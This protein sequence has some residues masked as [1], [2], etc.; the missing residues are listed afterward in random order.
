MSNLAPGYRCR[1]AISIVTILSVAGA[2]VAISGAESVRAGRTAQITGADLQIAAL[3]ISRPE[4]AAGE[5]VVYSI[6]AR[7]DGPEAALGVRVI[8]RLP[9]GLTHVVD[10]SGGAYDVATGR[11]TIGSMEPG[12]SARLAITTTVQSPPLGPPPSGA[13]LGAFV[14]AG[15]GGLAGPVDLVFGP[16]GD[17]FVASALTD[18]VLR[19]DG[20]SGSAKGAFVSA[21]AGG[22]DVPDGLVFGPDGALYVAS[23]ETDAVLRFDGV[24]GAFESIFVAAGA[25]GLAGPA[26]LLFAPSGELIVASA[27]SSAVLRFSGSDGSFLG[28]LVAPGAGGLERPFGLALD[29]AGRIYV[30]D[31]PGDAVRRY[32]GSTGAPLGDFVTTGAGGLV[33]PDR[34]VF[35]PD[36]ALYVSNA[37]GGNV[38][39]FNGITG[40][41]TRVF[42]DL[43]AGGFGS[44]SGLVFGPEGDLLVS[45]FGGNAVVQFAG[46]V[47]NSARIESDSPYDPRPANNRRYVALAIRSGSMAA[48]A[49]L[50]LSMT[51]AGGVDDV[52]APGGV[53]SSPSRVTAGRGLAMNLVVTNAGPG[54]APGA[55]AR[56]TLPDGVVFVAGIV[57]GGSGDACRLEASGMFASIVRC[58]VGALVVGGLARVR[59]TTATAPGLAAGSTLELRATVGSDASEAFHEDN[60]ASRSVVVERRSDLEA[61]LEI[62]PEGPAG[63]AVVGDE[64]AITLQATNLGPSV[65]PAAGLSLTLPA[66]LV[67]TEVTGDGA[68]CDLPAAGV[69]ACRTTEI[70]PG[71]AARVVL[72][73]L[74]SDGLPGRMLESRGNV[75]A[76]DG[77]DLYGANDRAA[78]SLAIGEGP[79]PGSESESDVSVVEHVAEPT[80]PTPLGTLTFRVRVRNAGPGQARGVRVVHRL[81]PGTEYVPG[82]VGP[83]V[84]EP[85]VMAGRWVIGSM[86]AGESAEIEL[87]ARVTGIVRPEWPAATGMPR[88]VLGGGD[89]LGAPGKLV[90]G[91]DGDI[92]VA[93]GRGQVQRFDG[94]TGSR[95]PDFVPAGRELL[96][97]SAVAWGPDGDLYVADATS[98]G[99]RRFD[100]VL[101]SEKPMFVTPGAGGLASPSD[102]AWGSDGRLY[103]ADQLGSRILRFHGRTGEFHDVVVPEGR[104][105]L[106][107]PSAIA[108]GP[109]G[110]LWVSSFGSGE[111]LRFSAGSGDLIGRMAVRSAGLER[112]ST[113]LF[114]LFG[115]LLASGEAAGQVWRFGLDG[116]PMGRFVDD[117]SV[118]AGVSGLAFGLDGHLL[119][120]DTRRGRVGRND[121][122]AMAWARASRSE[123]V[124]INMTNDR[125][126]AGIV[127]P[128][129]SPPEPTAS[130]T[131]S[132]TRTATPGPGTDTPPASTPE[133]ILLPI[134]A[135]R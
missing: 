58:D 73:A 113:I 21:G 102:L 105:G 7:N 8:D 118:G 98:D 55:H 101:G 18:Q 107:V 126:A 31:E 51:V 6:V 106:S 24:T 125:L 82:H 109:D 96:F 35:G 43:D 131:P 71:E 116:T 104:G 75:A 64:I 12:A 9:V 67:A 85:G 88:G 97:A 60:A 122:F 23:A 29:A 59:L 112:P 44:S 90:L 53:G 110:D 128:P 2:F 26:D 11:W 30:A 4:A 25:G 39:R 89:P 84:F 108:F 19:F 10:D 95:L 86:A 52:G 22:L 49:D 57:E 14:P 37:G 78:T 100:G 119:V 15:D 123:G 56:I 132:G 61:G 62:E 48:E 47:I 38:L 50:R 87:T 3:T 135:N 40:A 115:D 70:Q 41:F 69:L 17:L 20:T 16:D 124:D 127:L 66:G 117:G 121:G 114:G 76:P 5:S 92:Y 13:W 81:P 46:L 74:L 94:A 54:V 111:I 79:G 80:S 36:G 134:V 27:D 42:A 1:L 68:G 32:D 83:G 77:A 65:S 120:S 91:P 103:V 34:L 130:E 63:H 72:R 133:A 99:V 33:G 45:S 129:G 28:T 93:D